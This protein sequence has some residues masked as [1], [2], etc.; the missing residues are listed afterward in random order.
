MIKNRFYIVLVVVIAVCTW[1][2]KKVYTPNVVSSAPNYLV[3]EGVINTGADSTTIKLSRTTNLADSAKTIKE[4]GASL[5]VEDNTGRRHNLTEFGNGL[6]KSAPLNL[7]STQQC[8]LHIIT[9]DQKEYVSDFVDNIKTPAIDSITYTITGTGAQ[10]YANTHDPTGTVKYYRWD[11]DETWQYVAL[12][13]SFYKYDAINNKIVP[14]AGEN[15]Y[16]CW[17]TNPSTQVLLG[18]TAG[19]SQAVVSALP[20]SY[21]DE[22]TGKLAHG[23][24]ML[25]R[26]YGLTKEAYEYWQKLKKNTEQLGSIFDAQPSALT[27]NLHNVNDAKEPVLGYIS[28]STV[29]VKRF[30]IGHNAIPLYSQSYFPPPGAGDCTGGTINLLPAN[31]F[32]ARLKAAMSSGNFTLTDDNGSAG[33]LIGYN[34]A[35]SECVDCRVKLLGGTNIK[36]SYWP[37]VL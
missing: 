12:L 23:Y 32:D 36:P 20:V 22:S 34:Y 2:C 9:K 31:T 29:S 24:S 27:G 7:Q 5:Y 35:S 25:L 17:K 21:V 3:V 16:N 30:L 14:R 6:Y 8:R 18:S 15:I 4:L 33:V 13:Q 26:Q 28:A 1:Q 37:D 11:F 10:F 19:L